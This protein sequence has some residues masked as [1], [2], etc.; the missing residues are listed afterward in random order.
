MTRGLS[1]PANG[2]LHAP[3]RSHTIH[4]PARAQSVRILAGGP[5]LESVIT[6][7]EGVA[8]APAQD[9]ATARAPGNADHAAHETAAPAHETAGPAH[10]TGAPVRVT[11]ARALGTAIAAVA[12]ADAQLGASG[13]LFT[14]SARAC[15]SILVIIGPSA[16]AA[17]VTVKISG[18][19][20]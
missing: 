4:F 3:A 10:E 13:A 14:S 11:A 9:A 17:G 16:T 15:V 2:V 18:V 6:D 19:V 8:R 5:I 7:R 20:S 1:R 12:D